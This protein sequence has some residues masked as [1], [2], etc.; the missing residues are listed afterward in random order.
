[1]EFGS[2]ANFQFH[3]TDEEL[4][5]KN[6]NEQTVQVKY[7][8][9]D[10]NLWVTV[11]NVNINTANNTVTFSSDVIGNF[12]ILTGDSP[13][14]VQTSNDLIVDDFQLLQNYPNPFNPSTTINFTIA[15]QSNV[16]L[17]VFNL[18]GQKVAD[19]VNGNME[20]GNYNVRFD[21]SNLSSGVYLYQLRT[22]GATIVKKMQL[23]K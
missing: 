22:D 5:L 1:M 7:W 23:L 12:F 8:N 17:S 3:Y 10:S 21:A 9:T 14:S 16:S 20:P 13:T 15:K 19:L 11:S 18:L 6:I 4:N 2:N